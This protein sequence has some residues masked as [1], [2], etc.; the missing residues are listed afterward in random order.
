M[1]EYVLKGGTTLTDDQI[2]E[3]ARKAEQGDYP[4]SPGAWVIR[5]QGRPVQYAEDLVTVTLRVPASMRDALD[6][7]ARA[8]GKTRSQFLRQAIAQAI[9]WRGRRRAQPTGPRTDQSCPSL[10]KSCRAGSGGR[11]F[12]LPSKPYG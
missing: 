2:E 1:A 6:Q 8:E 5:P 4:G 7:K 9:A 3:L 11:T 12:A 10:R